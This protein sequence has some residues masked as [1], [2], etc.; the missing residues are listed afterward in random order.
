MIDHQHSPDKPPD[1]VD[2]DSALGLARLGLMSLA[3]GALVAIGIPAARFL[4]PESAWEPAMAAILLV[5][6]VL[7]GAGIRAGVLLANAMDREKEV[8]YTTLHGVHR[9]LWQ[10]DPKT[11]E[12]LR[13]PGERE[14]RR[15]PRNGV[16]D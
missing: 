1:L 5:V 15:R 16:L 4:L 7:A 13:R 12:V 2:G 6:L 3:A 8:G 9:D 11:G 10:L 14:V